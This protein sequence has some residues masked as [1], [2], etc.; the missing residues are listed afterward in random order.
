MIQKDPEKTKETQNS[1]KLLRKLI[2]ASTDREREKIQS[3]QNS[4][5]VAS[6]QRAGHKIS[7]DVNELSNKV[8]DQKIFTVKVWST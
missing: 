7:N 5:K 8:T 1:Q 2:M 3:L 6:S 4:V